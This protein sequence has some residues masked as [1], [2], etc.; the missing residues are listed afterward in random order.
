MLNHSS[1]ETQKMAIKCEILFEKNPKRVFYAG[2]SLYGSIRLTL[3]NDKNVRGIFVKING[4]AITIC[5]ADNF[6]EDCLNDRLE[7]IGDTRL[8]AGT[9][10]FPFQFKL[11]TQ[12]PSSYE[13]EYG[14]IRYTVTVS[15]EIPKIPHKEF[16]KRVT[17]L[18]LTDLKDPD[19]Q[20]NCKDY[21]SAN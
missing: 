12:L 15:V 19:L 8:A 5:K 7:I 2:R 3:T 1:R 9:H 20:V 6:G 16:E 18:R 17:I 21:F 13:G 11:P 10:E 14:F 4:A